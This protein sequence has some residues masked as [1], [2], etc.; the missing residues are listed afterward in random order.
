MLFNNA[1]KVIEIIK[2]KDMSKNNYALQRIGRGGGKSQ[3]SSKYNS[4]LHLEQL[5]TRKK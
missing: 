2:Y 3:L 1:A 4:D 5:R